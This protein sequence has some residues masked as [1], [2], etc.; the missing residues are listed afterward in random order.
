MCRG[1][2]QAAPFLEWIRANTQRLVGVSGAVHSS[3][4]KSQRPIWAL[5]YAKQESLRL[6]GWM[7][8][9]P[10]VPCLARK[11]LKAEKFLSRLDRAAGRAV[12]RRR[13]GWLYTI[14]AKD[15]GR[16]G[17]TA[18]TLDSKS[19]AREGVRVQLP[20]PVPFLDKI[21]RAPVGFSSRGAVAQLGEHKAGSLGV[22]GSTPLSSTN[23]K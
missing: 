3:A 6:L 14:P 23:I 13:V 12:G 18:A 15:K 2:L 9:S 4:G 20:P 10:D 21:P 1:S 17:V 5:R 19:S 16:G 8:H 7:Y 11:R 22:R